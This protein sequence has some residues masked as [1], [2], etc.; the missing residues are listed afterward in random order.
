M[1]ESDVIL[2]ES[3]FAVISELA[4]KLVAIRTRDWVANTE[5][6]RQSC[7]EYLEKLARRIIARDLKLATDDAFHTSNVVSRMLFER[8]AY[9][10]T[11]DKLPKGVSSTREAVIEWI[12]RDRWESH[13]ASEAALREQKEKEIAEAFAATEEGK[14]VA[15]MKNLDG[16]GDD[17]E[18]RFL[19]VIQKALGK[20]VRINNSTDV[21][22]LRD[23][24]RK[25]V[26]SGYV[27]GSSSGKRVLINHSTGQF[28]TQKQLTKTGIDFAQYLLDK[29]KNET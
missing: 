8:I 16:F 3:D 19:G 28:C 20:L 10:D 22:P 6:I 24:I 2:S 17:L 29:V 25:L 5:T 13:L 21:F 1:N 11:G 18:P 23:A 7:W 9:R 14:A 4:P 12:G 27:P 15:A 26:A